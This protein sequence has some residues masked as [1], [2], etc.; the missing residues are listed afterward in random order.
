MA[1]RE[2]RGVG[3][4]LLTLMNLLSFVDRQLLSGFANFIVPDLE[5]TKSQ[6]GLLTGL[7]REYTCSEASLGGLAFLMA[8]GTHAPAMIAPSERSRQ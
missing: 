8:D 4:D 3:L 7:T 1:A 6:F 5:L 2:Q